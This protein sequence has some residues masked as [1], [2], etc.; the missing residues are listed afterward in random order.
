MTEREQ[1]LASLKV[2]DEVAVKLDG[3]R[4]CADMVKSVLKTKINL[5]DHFAVSIKTGLGIYDQTLSIHPAMTADSDSLRIS[6]KV[7][8]IKQ[9]LWHFMDESQL[10]AILAII[11]RKETNQ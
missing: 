7:D 11:E 10:D 1:W 2:G 3:N 9:T 6:D 4:V 8:R 5:G